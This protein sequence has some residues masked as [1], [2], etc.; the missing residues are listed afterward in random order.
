MLNSKK[1]KNRKFSH[2]SFFLK[3]S[4]GQ[5][6]ETIN[7]VIATL[8]I[9]GIL[10]LFIYI[11]TLMAKAKSL[12]VGDL[13]SDLSKKNLILSEKTAFAHQLYGNKDKGVIDKIILDY[14]K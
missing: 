5:T 11:S 9:I 6:G 3:N 2:C 13:N 4:K 8:V 10:I 12:T 1:E 7:W 14:D